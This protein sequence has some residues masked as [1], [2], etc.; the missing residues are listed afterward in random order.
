MD[1][2]E[3]VKLEQLKQRI[4]ANDADL[5]GSAFTNVNLSDSIFDDVSLAGATIHNANLSRQRISDADLR[6]SAFT[7]V[8]LS[9]SIF[10]DV[11]LA[12]ATIHNANLSRLRISDADLRGASIVESQTDGMTINGIAVA[13]MLSAYRAAHAKPN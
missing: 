11:N 12:G 8:N 9:D 3:T 5:R 10:D 7:N 13:E 2:V 4:E 1:T 6:G